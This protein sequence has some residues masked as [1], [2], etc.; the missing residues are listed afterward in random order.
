MLTMVLK[1]TGKCIMLSKV[2]SLSY[3][4]KFIRG[5]SV[6]S[7]K[8]GNEIQSVDAINFQVKRDAVNTVVLHETRFDCGSIDGFI[9]ATNQE[10]KKKSDK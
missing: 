1:I 2:K 5:P 9:S 7:F 4:S 10:N 8:I 3:E 6:I